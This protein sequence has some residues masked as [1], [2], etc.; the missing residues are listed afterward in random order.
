MRAFPKNLLFSCFA[1]GLSLPLP[2]RLQGKTAR[3]ILRPRAQMNQPPGDLVLKPLILSLCLMVAPTM[4]AEGW[5]FEAGG[6]PIAY[7]DNGDAQ[8]QFACRGGDLAMGYWVRKPTDPVAKAQS[9]NLGMNA[10]G[11]KITA[12]AGTSFAQDMPL[13]HSDGTSMIVRG[14]VARQ[15]AQLARNA[16]GTIHLAYVRTGSDGSLGVHDAHQFSARGSS[17]AIAEVLGRCR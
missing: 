15:W 5:Q 7:I 9:M 13:I 3:L 1:R 17:A 2:S 4:A 12:E 10:S 6:V 8:F 14:P 11:G 16:A